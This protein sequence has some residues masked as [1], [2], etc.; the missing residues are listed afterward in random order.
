MRQAISN[1]PWKDIPVILLLISD[2]VNC[3]NYDNK[4]NYLVSSSSDLSIK[5]WDL[6]NDYVCCK[7]FNGHDHNV[8][9]VNFV[10]DSDY[11]ISCSRDKTIKLWEISTGFNTRTYHGH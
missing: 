8:S 4:G 1:E 10:F 7:T 6:N 5:L 11:L 3:V 9:F 2:P